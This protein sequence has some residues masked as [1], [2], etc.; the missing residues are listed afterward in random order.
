[1][2]TQLGYFFSDNGAEF[3][4]GS[5]DEV[6]ISNT[7]RSPAWDRH[8]LHQPERSRVLLRSGDSGSPPVNVAF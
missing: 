3:F 4:T 6:R 2:N 8:Q 7:L 5:L 1:M